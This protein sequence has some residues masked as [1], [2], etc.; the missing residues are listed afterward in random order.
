[1]CMVFME[2]LPVLPR[3][4]HHSPRWSCQSKLSFYSQQVSKASTFP[5]LG[6]LELFYYY[7]LWV[8]FVAITFLCVPLSWLSDRN[9]VIATIFNR[10]LERL[11]NCPVLFHFWWAI[12][13]S[14]TT[15]CNQ[16]QCLVV[17]LSVAWKSIRFIDQTQRYCSITDV[18]FARSCSSGSLHYHVCVSLLYLHYSFMNSHSTGFFIDLCS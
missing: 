2:L 15:T 11:A 10:W 7:F 18:V 4:R 13:R 8:C 6:S 17:T 14:A 16:I 12:L 5:N 9:Y 3:F 1:M